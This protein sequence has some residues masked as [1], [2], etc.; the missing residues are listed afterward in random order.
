MYIVFCNAISSMGKKFENHPNGIKEMGEYVVECL[1]TYPEAKITIDRFQQEVPK[2]HKPLVIDSNTIL[3]GRLNEYQKDILNLLPIQK[4]IFDD[5][6]PTE[7]NCEGHYYDIYRKNSFK[8][9]EKRNS[10]YKKRK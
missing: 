10:F 2:G 4:I 7:K 8:E 1:T 6:E 3:V 5:P 9:V